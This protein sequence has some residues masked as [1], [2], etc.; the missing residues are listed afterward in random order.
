[1][2]ADRNRFCA[3]DDSIRPRQSIY[4]SRAMNRRNRNVSRRPRWRC[5]PSRKP[6]PSPDTDSGGPS[7]HSLSA[8]PTDASHTTPVIIDTGTFRAATTAGLTTSSKT[9]SSAPIGGRERVITSSDFRSPRGEINPRG[10]VGPMWGY[11]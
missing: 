11:E 8:G 3:V 2:V 9:P 5:I 10:R 6:T 4:Q 7:N 1:M